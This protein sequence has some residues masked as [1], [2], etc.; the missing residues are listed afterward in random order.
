MSRLLGA[1]RLDEWLM[2]Y[3]AEFRNGGL[4]TCFFTCSHVR[5]ASEDA[6]FLDSAKDAGSVVS[7]AMVQILD[8]LVFY[9]VYVHRRP[10][11]LSCSKG[12]KSSFSTDTLSMA[13]IIF[14]VETPNA[15]SKLKAVVSGSD[16]RFQRVVGI[17]RAKKTCNLGFRPITVK[18]N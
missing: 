5:E 1:S 7:T 11:H 18:C 14:F 16:T 3:W 17:R 4:P 15:N 8:S 13:R 2:V 12:R 10:T 6:W 9:V